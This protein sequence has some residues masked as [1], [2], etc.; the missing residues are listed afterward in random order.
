VAP[1]PP[2]IGWEEAKTF[3]HTMQQG[4]ADERRVLTDTARQVLASM[5]GHK[6]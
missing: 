4:D 1:L 6:E 2:H 5:T 3:M